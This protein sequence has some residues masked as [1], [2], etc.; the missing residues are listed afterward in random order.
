MLIRKTV[1]IKEVITADERPAPNHP[2][3]RAAALCV[4]QNPFAGTDQSDLTPLFE[5]GARLGENL[6]P[7]VAQMLAGEPVSYGK[8]AIVGAAGV[9]EHGAAMIHPRLGKPM[10]AAV[11]GG[12]ALIASNVKVGAPGVP[13]D[14]PLGHKDNAWSFDH[15]DTLTLSIADAPRAGE[16]VLCIALSDGPRAHARVGKGPA[17]S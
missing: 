12:D 1:F 7:Q 16:I 17:P 14:I 15:I 3:T 5:L 2:I 13:I 10:R 4:V 11:G 6:S 8:A 9:M